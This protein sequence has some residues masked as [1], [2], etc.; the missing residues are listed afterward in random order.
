MVHRDSTRRLNRVLYRDSTER[1]AVR[2]T[3]R[4]AVLASE[5]SPNGS[6]LR[7]A[8]RIAVRMAFSTLFRPL[9]RQNSPDHCSGDDAKKPHPSYKRVDFTLSQRMQKR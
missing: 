8:F 9:E 6:A 5:L 3:V 7:M 2:I 4:I 1:D